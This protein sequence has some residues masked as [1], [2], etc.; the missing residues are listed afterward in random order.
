MFYIKLRA[1]HDLERTK[2]FSV[3]QTFPPNHLYQNRELPGDREMT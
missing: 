2:R 3:S 1:E